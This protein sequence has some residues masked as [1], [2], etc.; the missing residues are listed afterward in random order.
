[1]GFPAGTSDPEDPESDKTVCGMDTAGIVTVNG[2]T[3][4][5]PAGR[6]GKLMQLKIQDSLII[7]IL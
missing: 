1:M 4:R 3:G 7:D 2:K 6:A 5:M